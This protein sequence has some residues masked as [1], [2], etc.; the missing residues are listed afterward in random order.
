LS[1]RLAT[2]N[3]LS[4]DCSNVMSEMEIVFLAGILTEAASD[5]AA[6]AIAS[7][8]LIGGTAHYGALLASKTEAEVESATAIGFFVGL[9]FGGIALLME[10]VT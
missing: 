5:V 7:T 10:A 8:G 9:G 1:D 4:E 2:S 3:V 6:L